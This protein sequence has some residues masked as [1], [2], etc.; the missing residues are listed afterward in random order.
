MIKEPRS[1]CGCSGG[2]VCSDDGEGFCTYKREIL[3]IAMADGAGTGQNI[4]FLSMPRV[5]CIRA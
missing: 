2:F 3:L 1:V 4:I 5:L